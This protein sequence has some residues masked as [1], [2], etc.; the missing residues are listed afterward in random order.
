MLVGGGICGDTGPLPPTQRYRNLKQL[1]S[2]PP[3][4]FV[5]P[6]KCGKADLNCAAIGNIAEG[7]YSVLLVNNA[8][9]R[10]AT[11]TGLPASVKEVRLRVTDSK[12]G[13]EE[14]RLTYA[15]AGL[16]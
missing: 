3:R 13:M 1:A 10:P 5:L 11:R 9:A 16:E 2:A 7:K 8:A 14:S 6:V 15:C 12:R 4:S